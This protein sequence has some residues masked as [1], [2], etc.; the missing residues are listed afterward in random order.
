MLRRLQMERSDYT[1]EYAERRQMNVGA[2]CTSTLDAIVVLTGADQWQNR[3][4]LGEVRRCSHHANAARRA[5]F[6]SK[7]RRVPRR[8]SV[9][10]CDGQRSREDEQRFATGRRRRRFFEFEQTRLCLPAPPLDLT[11]SAFAR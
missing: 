1:A 9:A 10:H 3:T 6:I 7:A 2:E 8:C 5:C 4:H 11:R